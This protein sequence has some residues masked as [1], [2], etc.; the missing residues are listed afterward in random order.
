MDLL[1]QSS[2]LVVNPIMV[3]CHG[4]LFNCTTMGQASDLTKSF[5]QLVS[6]CLWLGVDQLEVF[7]S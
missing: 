3:Y 2:C 1:G 6:S 5:S 7:V 4:F